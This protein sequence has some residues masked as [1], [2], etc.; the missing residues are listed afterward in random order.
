LRQSIFKAIELNMGKQGW[1]ELDRK[2]LQAV[3]LHDKLKGKELSPEDI[4]SLGGGW[5][6][7]EALAI[8]LLCALHYP[9]NFE[10]GVLVSVNHSGDSDSTGSI[11]GNILGLINGLERIPARWVSGLRHVDL[12]LQMSEDLAI[13]MKGNTY[14]RDQNWMEKYPPN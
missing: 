8:S 5:V 12:V 14:E 4:E 1:E 7:E 2:V 13:G 3:S 10:K 6:A 9:D 11:T